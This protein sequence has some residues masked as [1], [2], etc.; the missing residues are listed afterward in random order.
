LFA[1]G[2]PSLISADN[3]EATIANGISTTTH[4][5][6]WTEQRASM[7]AYDYFNKHYGVGIEIYKHFLPYSQSQKQ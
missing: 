6:F 1:I 2:V 3:S 7:S 5:L 4:K